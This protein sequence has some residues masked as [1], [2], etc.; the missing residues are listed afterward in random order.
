MREFIHPAVNI[1]EVEP[2]TASS[3]LV[4]ICAFRKK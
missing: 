1:L 2:R 4:S 3:V